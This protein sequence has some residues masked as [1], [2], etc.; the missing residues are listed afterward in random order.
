MIDNNESAGCEE[1]HRGKGN[2]WPG[3]GE[4]LK[5]NKMTDDGE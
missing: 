4:V 3:I 1:R 2:Q 5:V